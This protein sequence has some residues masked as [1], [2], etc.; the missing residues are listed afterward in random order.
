MK[1]TLRPFHPLL[2]GAIAVALASTSGCGWFRTHND[3][4]RSVENRP[5][6]VPPDLDLPETANSLPMPS[7]ARAGGTAQ[8]PIAFDVADSPASVF[9]RM[10]AALATIDGVTVTGSAAGL[11]SY[12]VA[13]QGQNFLVRVEDVAGQ[14]RISAISASGQMLRAGPAAVLL[15]KLRA[16]L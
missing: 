13:Y 9:T 14:S 7:A 16:K 15:G 12:D 8:S 4:A 5:L 3:Y 2:V 10:G 1:S 6:E 11:G